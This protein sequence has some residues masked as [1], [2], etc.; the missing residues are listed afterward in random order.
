LELSNPEH[1]IYECYPDDPRRQLL[2][3]AITKEQFLSQELLYHPW[4]K[5]GLRLTSEKERELFGPGPSP[6]IPVLTGSGMASG[7]HTSQ[8]IS[9]AQ[10]FSN[11]IYMLSH[12]MTS[13]FILYSN[14][15]SLKNKHIL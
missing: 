11:G 14:F 4:W 5:T 13:C 1:F 10:I 2:P 12:R 3:E 6:M 8:T 9:K 7:L 15:P